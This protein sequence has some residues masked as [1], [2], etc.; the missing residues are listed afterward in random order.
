MRE[1]VVEK[2]RQDSAIHKHLPHFSEKSNR[3]RER[4]KER[5]TDERMIT[6]TNNRKFKRYAHV[7]LPPINF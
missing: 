2:T 3:K 4:K 5:K 6:A 7:K 1:K